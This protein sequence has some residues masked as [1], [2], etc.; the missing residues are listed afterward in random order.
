MPYLRNPKWIFPLQ[1]HTTKL[2]DHYLI[3]LLPIV[4]IL[5][6]HNTGVFVKPNTIAR[7]IL[8]DGCA[9]VT[10]FFVYID[11]AN[12]EPWSKL[13][14]GWRF[15]FTSHRLQ[16]TPG[17]HPIY[18]FHLLRHIDLHFP[19]FSRQLLGF[20]TAYLMAKL[21][22]CI[23]AA[24]P[25]SILTANEVESHVVSNT[26]LGIPAISSLLSHIACAFASG[27]LCGLNSGTTPTVFPL[28][29]SALLARACYTSRQGFV[30]L[31]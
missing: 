1:P 10:T 3:R 27:F 19:P 26:S 22:Q 12:K 23:P 5:E 8:H 17:G 24:F 13:T 21:V 25:P 2:F 6:R 4:R 7:K 11:R 16:G 15:L 28:I 29:H 20:S 30:S 9:S 31:E 14:H 18:V